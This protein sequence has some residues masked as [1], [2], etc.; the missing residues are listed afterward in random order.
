MTM[1]DVRVGGDVRLADLGRSQ[2]GRRGNDGGKSG[3]YE[4]GGFEMKR[5]RAEALVRDAAG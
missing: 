5:D 1:V 3:R 2:G 4:G